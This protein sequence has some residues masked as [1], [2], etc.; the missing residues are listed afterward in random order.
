M[1]STR[2]ETRGD[3][4]NPKKTAE[5]LRDRVSGWPREVVRAAV[6]EAFSS[7]GG[8]EILAP[9]VAHWLTDSAPGGEEPPLSAMLC[10]RVWQSINWRRQ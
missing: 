8:D 5:E 6:L 10:H 3:G 1:W 7:T 4:I 9:V 2:G